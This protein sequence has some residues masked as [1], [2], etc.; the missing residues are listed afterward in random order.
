MFL[1][2]GNDQ[3]ADDF[4]NLVEWLN[5]GSHCADMND[6]KDL[7]SVEVIQKYLTIFE[8]TFKITGN[9]GQY[10]RLIRQ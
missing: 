2:D 9:H 10:I 8:K 7:P 5:E 3:E 1:E 6:F 4:R